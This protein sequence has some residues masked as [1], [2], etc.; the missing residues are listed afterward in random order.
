MR[1]PAAILAVALAAAALPG[2]GGE[3][4]PSIPSTIA[5]GQT[6]VAFTAKTRARLSSDARR[7]MSVCPA[8]SATAYYR[9]VDYA[10]DG[11]TADHFFEHELPY[12]YG[13][14][15]PAVEGVSNV[16]V[17]MRADA[18]AAA[19]D[20]RLTTALFLASFAGII[21]HDQCEPLVFG[22]GYDKTR[23]TEFAAALSWARPA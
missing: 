22:A 13:W 18:Y 20:G 23:L 7:W 1:T 3:S 14:I 5:L 2:C 11:S 15:F 8:V 19:L 16:G 9:N 17:Y 12:G 21:R 6:A 10:D 4:E